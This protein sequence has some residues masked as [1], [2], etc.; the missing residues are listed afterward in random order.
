MLA[1]LDVVV[2]NA[3]QCIPIGFARECRTPRGWPRWRRNLHHKAVPGVIPGKHSFGMAPGSATGF[4]ASGD[5]RI[6]V[7]LV[8]PNHVVIGAVIDLVKGGTDRIACGIA[9]AVVSLLQGRRFTTRVDKLLAEVLVSLWL[10]AKRA[11]PTGAASATRERRGIEL[12]NEPPIN[13]TSFLQKR[14]QR[15]T[16]RKAWGSAALR[17]DHYVGS[18][19]GWTS[20]RRRWA[21]FACHGAVQQ[22]DREW[23]H[24]ADRPYDASAGFRLSW[25]HGCRLLC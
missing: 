10:T 20:G 22:S 5:L 17:R 13:W 24:S 11:R 16:R 23:N 9:D 3:A 18:D 2:L 12:E 15:S 8:V 7:K 19:R 14:R 4:A 1:H 25:R 6:V 21:A